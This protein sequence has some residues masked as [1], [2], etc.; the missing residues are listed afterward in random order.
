LDQ[1]PLDPHFDKRL[2]MFLKFFNDERANNLFIA[3][4]SSH[5]KVECNKKETTTQQSRM[6]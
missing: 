3:M 2:F 1:A 6:V 5:S 4:L